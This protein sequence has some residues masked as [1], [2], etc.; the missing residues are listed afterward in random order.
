MNFIVSH[1]QQLILTKINLCQP[2][3]SFSTSHGKIAS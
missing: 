3:T 1:K 2:I